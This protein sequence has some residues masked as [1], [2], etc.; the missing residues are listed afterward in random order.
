V[1]GQAVPEKVLSPNEFALLTAAAN[2]S[3]LNFDELP[4]NVI[5][6]EFLRDLLIQTVPPHVVHPTGISIAGA[7]VVGDIE[8]TNCKSIAPFHAEGCRFTG[9]V[10][11]TNAEMSVISLHNCSLRSLQADRVRVTGHVDLTG[12][13]VSA[14]VH[15]RGAEIGDCLILSGASVTAPN[16][17]GSTCVQDIEA[18]AL[19]GIRVSRNIYLSRGCKIEGQ[20]CLW[21]ARI[22]GDAVFN[23][24][25]FI[26]RHCMQGFEVGVPVAIELNAADIGG[27]L[28]LGPAET[29][30]DNEPVRVEGGID[31]RSAKVGK[32]LDD[33]G[34]WPQ[35]GALYLDG[36]VY[37]RLDGR[38][39]H[40]AATRLKWLDLQ[41]REFRARPQPFTQLFRVFSDMGLERE[42]ERISRERQRRQII[43]QLAEKWWMT[44]WLLMK[45]LVLGLLMGFGYRPQRLLA[46]AGIVWIAMALLYGVAAAQGIFAPSNP[47][48]Y[49]NE[50][51][52]GCRPQN[53]GN[54]VKCDIPELTDFNAVHY[55][56]D[57]LMAPL[58]LEMEHDWSPTHRS[59]SLSLPWLGHVQ[60]TRSF[61]STM[62]LCE[63]IFG[64]VVFVL[65]GSYLAGLLRRQ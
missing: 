33:P 62:Q 53:G 64:W 52:A 55:S 47:V 46:V 4:D 60:T 39:P 13:K 23:G 21:A 12:S 20:T 36:F 43:S 58:D 63:S 50:A 40:N 25:T 16:L 41:P 56:L 18:L 6:G 7:D 59:M 44:P 61:V 42:A 54:W 19:E 2:G 51:Y 1:H 65:I 49:L 37:G 48:I 10:K 57:V 27:T 11:F 14:G 34:S 28:W 26:N 45:W 32:L 29:Y 24:G 35:R 3:K 22:K 9:D 30:P 17:V 5:S 8:L 38:S 15:L 31:L